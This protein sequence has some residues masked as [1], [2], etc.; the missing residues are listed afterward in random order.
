M[1]GVVAVDVEAVVGLGKSEPL[2]LRQRFAELEALFV[3]PR[4]DVVARAVNDAVNGQDAVGNEAFPQGADDRNAAGDARLKEKMP[5]VPER[6][7]EK[8]RAA[9]SKKCLVRGDDVLAVLQCGLDE[10]EGLGRA[11][12]QLDDDIE[13]GIGH[14]LAPIG[15][16]DFLRDDDFLRAPGPPHGNLIDANLRSGPLAQEVFLRLEPT[17][18]AGAHGAKTS[19]TN[20]KNRCGC[21]HGSDI[22]SRTIA[23]LKWKK[24]F[25]KVAAANSYLGCIRTPKDFSPPT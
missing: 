13:I 9:S 17:P 20:T 24:A 14:E 10:L 8:F 15:D 19:Q 1:R 5:L 4:E 7:L 18:D 22:R 12:N 2:G 23:E 16:G 25:S 3:H 21:T 11:A 6:R